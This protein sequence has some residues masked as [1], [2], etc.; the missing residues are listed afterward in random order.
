MILALFQSSG[1][2]LSLKHFVYIFSKIVHVFLL[3]FFSSSTVILISFCVNVT[4][5]FLPIIRELFTVFILFRFCIAVRTSSS[6]AL[7]FLIVLHSARHSIHCMLLLDFVSLYCLSRVFV[8]LV[9]FF[10]VFRCSGPPISLAHWRTVFGI[11]TRIILF[12]ILQI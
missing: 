8:L 1:M 4:F 9:N 2:R 12:E 6:S 10:L 7:F 5:C 3:A 11:R